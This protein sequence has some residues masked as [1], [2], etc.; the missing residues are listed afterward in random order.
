MIRSLE[1]K[2]RNGS[3]RPGDRLPSEKTL[4][5]DFGV[6]RTVVREALQILK[7]R[8]MLESRR[9]SGSFVTSPS[10]STIGNSISWFA[11]LQ[12]DG[13]L[14]LELMDL[15]I[16]VET[17]A[18]RLVA[19]GTSSLA[20]IEKQHRLMEK[21]RGNPEHFADA[22]IEFHLALIRASGHSLFY[23]VEKG[24]MNALG[25][26]FARS[27]HEIAPERSAKVLAEHLLILTAIEKRNPAAA[28]KAMLAHLRR[29]RQNLLQRIQSAD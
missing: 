15:R 16:L 29:S 22:D 14:F 4:E 25:R 17:E 21:H 18:A 20:E 19:S 7:S 11:S 24:L 1:E 12:E 2:I 23:E 5:K 13:I 26:S 9:G 6:S 27:T 10:H 28:S 8:G 3:L